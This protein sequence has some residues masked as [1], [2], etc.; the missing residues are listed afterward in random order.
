MRLEPEQHRI[1]RFLAQQYAARRPEVSEGTLG[2]ILG[3]PPETLR[4][5]IDELEGRYVSV[6]KKMEIQN[7]WVK[8]SPGGEDYAREQGIM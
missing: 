7:R 5:H 8:L 4:Q 1:V 6:Q 2:S 3:M